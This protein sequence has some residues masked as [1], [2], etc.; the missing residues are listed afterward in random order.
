MTQSNYAINTPD[1]LNQIIIKPN[2][3]HFKDCILQNIKT[4][5]DSRNWLIVK[6]MHTF[7][8]N[9]IYII[10]TNTDLNYTIDDAN[11]DK[12]HFIDSPLDVALRD[13][14][15]FTTEN[16]IIK[17]FEDGFNKIPYTSWKYEYKLYYTK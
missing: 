17:P 6:R 12:I 5:F 13:S 10:Y 2:Y 9:D 15:Q 7:A 4:L 8:G 14:P 1:T 11:K 3:K 16:T